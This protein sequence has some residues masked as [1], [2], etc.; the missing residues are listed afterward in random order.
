[1]RLSESHSLPVPPADAWAALNDVAIL[2]RALP[3]CESLLEIA[4]DEFVADMAVPLGLSTPRFTVYVHR[5]EIEA[6][7]RCTLHFE[8]RTTGAVGTGSAALRLVPDGAGAT[9]LHADISLSLEGV[10]GVLGAPLIE[11]T[12]HEM[13]R[14]FLGG[15]RTFAA[16]RHARTPLP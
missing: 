8:T 4:P 13:T 14:Q 3:C 5:R 1:M 2:R 10:M 11:L 9:T 6:P 12:A 7:R 15:L 16:A